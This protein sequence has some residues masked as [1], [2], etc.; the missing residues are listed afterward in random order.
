MTQIRQVELRVM[1]TKL[2]VL[3]LS[4]KLEYNQ[5]QCMTD[6]HK[7]PD[8]TT[9]TNI[10]T[11][12]HK[13]FKRK[14]IVRKLRKKHEQ[15]KKRSKGT[16]RMLSIQV[17]PRV[18]VLH[19]DST[20]LEH[21]QRHHFLSQMASEPHGLPHA[22]RGAR[23]RQRPRIIGLSVATQGRLRRGD[24]EPFRSFPAPTSE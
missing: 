1:M 23:P 9:N 20:T 4:K 10:S 15:E 3:L 21:M 7:F 19:A 12:I 6:Q 11:Y 2:L 16:G 14:R 8:F 18:T 17:K 24:H 13:G 22:A 5:T